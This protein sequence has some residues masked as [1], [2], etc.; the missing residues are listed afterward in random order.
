MPIPSENAE[1]VLRGLDQ[2][3]SAKLQA[4]GTLERARNV[5]FDKAGQLDKRTGYAQLEATQVDGVVTPAVLSRLAVD[6]DELLVM[7]QSAAFAVLDAA[8]GMQGLERAM[9]SRGVMSHG[10]VSSFTVAVSTDSEAG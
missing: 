10:N 1:I 3:T 8:E 5:A 2:K 4:P 6:R 7:S 9:V